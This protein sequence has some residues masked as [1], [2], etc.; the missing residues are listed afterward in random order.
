MVTLDKERNV[1]VEQTRAFVNKIADSVRLAGEI[2]LG[3]ALP[4][5]A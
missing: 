4:L 2:A 5:A 1:V 3:D